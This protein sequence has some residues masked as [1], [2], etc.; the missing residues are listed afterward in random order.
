MSTLLDWMGQRIGA[1]LWPIGQVTAPTS[2]NLDL[3]RLRCVMSVQTIAQ[4]NLQLPH[5][6]E[7]HGCAM[8]FARCE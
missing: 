3:S 5:E 7:A 8:P 4:G 2:D 1:A 6:A